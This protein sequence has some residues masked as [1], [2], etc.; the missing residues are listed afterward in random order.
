MMEACDERWA[1]GLFEGE[2][3]VGLAK[4]KWRLSLA[5]TEEFVLLKFL[6]LVGGGRIYGPYH[7]GNPRHRVHWKWLC[8]RAE[9]VVAIGEM[10]LPYLGPTR[11]KKMEQAIAAMRK[12]PVRWRQQTLPAYPR[13]PEA[14][15]ERLK[16][17]TGSGKP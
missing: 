11:H 15:A 10:F 6:A 12:T 17:L 13:N 7:D 1:A 9:E 5:M 4:G 3:T 14:A 2:G 8:W 16:L